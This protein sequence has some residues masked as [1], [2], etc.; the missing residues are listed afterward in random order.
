MTTECQV[1]PA[2]NSD[3]LAL[4]WWIPSEFWEASLDQDPTTQPADKK[5]MLDALKGTS[6]IAIVQADITNFGTFKFYDEETVSKTRKLSYI[7]AEGKIHQLVTLDK[8]KPELQLVMGV[9]KPILSNAMG[10]M[11]KNFHFYVL[12]DVDAN[13]KRIIDP[14][15]KGT[16]KV[17]LQTKALENL[18]A[19]INYPLNSLFIPRLCPNGKKAHVTWEFCP[20]TGKKLD[21]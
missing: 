2:T 19:E 20:W 11:G 21:Q 12:D 15:K 18:S 4:A 14:Y 6:I 10:E 9:M 5:E 16:L 17:E 7:D 1:S 13:Q 3:H 8:I